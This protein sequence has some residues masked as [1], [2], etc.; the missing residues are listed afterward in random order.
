MGV[1][2][3]VKVRQGLSPLKRGDQNF[4]GSG[5]YYFEK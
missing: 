1:T 3:Q 5:A 2:R 4:G